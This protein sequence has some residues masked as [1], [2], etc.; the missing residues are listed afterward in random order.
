MQGAGILIMVMKWH[1]RRAMDRNKQLLFKRVIKIIDHKDHHYLQKAQLS[2]VDS[3]EKARTGII[4][5]KC[6]YFKLLK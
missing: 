3:T 4:F 1:N 6:F 5:Y 2:S